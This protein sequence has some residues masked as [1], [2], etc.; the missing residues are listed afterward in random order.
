M[1]VACIDSQKKL[2]FTFKTVT[3][4]VKKAPHGSW[5]TGFTDPAKSSIKGWLKAQKP[6]RG[7][8]VGIRPAIYT[9]QTCWGD[10]YIYKTCFR[11]VQFHWQ[12]GEVTIALKTAHP[13]LKMPQNNFTQLNF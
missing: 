9:Y 13:S 8:L 2:S 6:K 7:R 12:N 1:I 11:T 3:M 5:I 10:M 4:N